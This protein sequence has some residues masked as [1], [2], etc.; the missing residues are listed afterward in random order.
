[1]QPVAACQA[2]FTA[3]PQP[4]LP[5]PPARRQGTQNHDLHTKQG[6]LRRWA[7]WRLWMPWWGS[8][9]GAWP[10]LKAPVLAKVAQVLALSQQDRAAHARTGSMRCASPVTTPRP[11]CLGTTP[12][13]RSH[14]RWHTSGGSS[15]A[16]GSCH[17]GGGRHRHCHCA[18]DTCTMSNIKLCLGCA[19]HAGMHGSCSG[20]QSCHDSSCASTFMRLAFCCCTFSFGW[21]AEKVPRLA[22]RRLRTQAGAQAHC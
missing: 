4:P 22:F 7:T 1:M 8:S 14:S 20:W 3:T 2:L 18:G 13:S 10:R 17:Q 11:L 19:R 12:M 6:Q 16:Q 21:V 9:S 5:T 15:S